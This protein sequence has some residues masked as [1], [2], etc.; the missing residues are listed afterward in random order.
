MTTPDQ[1]LKLLVRLLRAA[2]QGEEVSEISETWR[3]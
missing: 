1:V 2:D 3:P